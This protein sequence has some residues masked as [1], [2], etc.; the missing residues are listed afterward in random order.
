MKTIVIAGF[1][2]LGASFGL[3]LADAGY[4]RICCTRNPEAREWALDNHAA[5][6]VSDRP[7]D[8]FPRADITFLALPIPVIPEYLRTYADSWRPGSIVSD[9]ASVKTPILAAAEEY[10]V[11]RDVRFVG[12]HPMA[13]T[14]FSGHAHA[15]RDMFYGANV[16]LCPASNAEA[17]KIGAVQNVWEHVG[18][19]VIG[20]TAA[21]HDCTV[22]YTSHVQHLIVDALVHAVLGSDDPRTRMLRELGCASGF[23][24]TTRLASSN[25][26]MWK[27][28]MSC[29][30][31]AVLD[32]LSRFEGELAKLHAM[33]A[34]GDFDAFEKHF[35][36]GKRLRDAR[37]NPGKK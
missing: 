7:S 14:E 12:G 37:F 4:R 35:A 25:P 8:V 28:I 6:E 16:F 5:D 23:R 11:P 17:D 22:A 32:A 1:G 18:A 31:P 34:D 9:M 2:L 29:N 19:H 3:A 36:E 27:E 10:L 26:L 33:I 13:G 15:L 30:A 24:D 21:E 20:L